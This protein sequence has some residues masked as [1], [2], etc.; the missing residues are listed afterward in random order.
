MEFQT[1]LSPELA[2]RIQDRIDKINGRPKNK[3]ERLNYAKD[4]HFLKQKKVRDEKHMRMVDKSITFLEA[5][6]RAII[7]R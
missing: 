6:K 3:G 1:N 7:S 2:K 5:S 4:H